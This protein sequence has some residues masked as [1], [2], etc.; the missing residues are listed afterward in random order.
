M[1]GFKTPNNKVLVAG[2]PVIQGL[3]VRGTLT[4]MKPGRFV[5]RDTTDA[6]CSIAGAGALNAIGVLGY[7]QAHSAYKPANVD[8]AY[9]TGAEA[10]ILSGPIVVR[11]YASEAIT[12]GA[13]VILAASGQVANYP[14]TPAAGDDRK[15][16]GKAQTTTSGAG[17]ILVELTQ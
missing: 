4:E 1:A 3:K 5:I 10:P 12:K 17:V 15:V 8:T 2:T 11:A 6:E 9:G 7:E 16:V 13:K 14:G